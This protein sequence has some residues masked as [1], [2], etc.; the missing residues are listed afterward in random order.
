MVLLK[1]WCFMSGKLCYFEISC[2]FSRV[3]DY[4]ECLYVYMYQSVEIINYFQQGKRSLKINK[5]GVCIPISQLKQTIFV[6][7]YY[8][9]T[10][11]CFD[12]I[13]D[14]NMEKIWHCLVFV[15]LKGGTHFGDQCFVPE[16]V[17]HLQ[18]GKY[19]LLMTLMYKWSFSR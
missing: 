4:F 12:F 11:L 14:T 16:K 1:V 8:L 17:L 13:H 19:I 15:I 3:W 5:K 9:M 2:C 18:T 7:N 6:Y 10:F